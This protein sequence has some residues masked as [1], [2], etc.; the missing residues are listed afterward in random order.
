[1][2]SEYRLYVRKKKKE[3]IH[4]NCPIIRNDITLQYYNNYLKRKS[5][6]YNNYGEH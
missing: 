6:Y 5:K 3:G 4:E 1:M 2:N